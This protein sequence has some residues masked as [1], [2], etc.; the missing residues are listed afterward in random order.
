MAVAEVGSVRRIDRTTNVLERIVGTGA[1]QLCGEQG[2]PLRVCLSAL[3]LDFA[4]NG[5]LWIADPENRRLWRVSGGA[6]RAYALGFAPFDVV[7]RSATEV[8]VADNEKRRILRFD[9]SSGR[10]TTV[11][12]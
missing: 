12:G 7:G 9:A 10:V 6:A 11:V 8:L 4:P 5:T 3:R 2:P 1:R